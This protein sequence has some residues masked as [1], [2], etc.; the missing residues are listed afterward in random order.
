MNLNEE[1]LPILR[2]LHPTLNI[3]LSVH[4][5]LYD[6]GGT[7]LQQIMYVDNSA[8]MY[9]YSDGR[10]HM[11]DKPCS[12]PIKYLHYIIEWFEKTYIKCY[13]KS[14]PKTI[15]KPYENTH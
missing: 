14:Y 11:T 8:F 1:L 7:F 12:D 6:M 10:R 13:D 2:I 15:R 3:S 4:T 5:A 9:V